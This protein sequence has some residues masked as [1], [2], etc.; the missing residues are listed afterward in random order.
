MDDLF[1]PY[2][3]LIAAV[4]TMSRRFFIRA[5]FVDDI[6]DFILP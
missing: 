1:L 3:L 6:L 4:S 5:R 2:L